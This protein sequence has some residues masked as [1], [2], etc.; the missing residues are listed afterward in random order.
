MTYHVNVDRLLYTNDSSLRDMW[1]TEIFPEEIGGRFDD[2]E[3]ALFF[4]HMLQPEPLMEEHKLSPG[5]YRIAIYETD[6]NNRQL[7][8]CRTFRIE[9]TVKW[10]RV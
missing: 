1:V 6:D 8:D 5:V 7:I 4:F 9:L 3:E 2:K 10:G